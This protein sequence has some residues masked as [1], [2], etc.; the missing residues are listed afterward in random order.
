MPANCSNCGA[1]FSVEQEELEWL[2]ANSK[3]VPM[4]CPRCRAF[5]TGV[6]DEPIACSVCGKIFIYPR[7]LKLFA[8][9]FG[10]ARPR[11]CLGGCK[12][13]GPEL[14]DEEKQ[15]TDFLRR[16]RAQRGMGGR[17]SANLSASLHSHTAPR[18]RLPGSALPVAAG[19]AGAP[20]AEG[21]GGEAGSA[22]GASLAQALRD[23]QQK[24][25]RRG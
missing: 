14:T 9:Q 20:G 15:M 16:L 18:A 24:K 4:M 21:A 10:W 25:R 7:E 22:L 1:G 13:Q 3:D 12:I 11:R 5:K 8:R 2:K 6:Q 23:F 19:E 17:L